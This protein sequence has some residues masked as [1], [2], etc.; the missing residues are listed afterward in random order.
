MA[1]TFD[2][3]IET[4]I[5]TLRDNLELIQDSR[6]YKKYLPYCKELF[7]YA[8]N[9]QSDYLFALYYYYMAEYYATD[10][11]CN[12]TINYALEGIKYQHSAQEYELEARSY[13][14]LGIFTDV[15]EDYSKS[16]D[17]YMSC[18]DLCNTY[19]FDHVHSMAAANLADVFR[20]NSNYERALY[21][22][23]ESERYHLREVKSCNPL[24]YLSYDNRVMTNKGYCLLSIKQLDIA[25][26]YGKKILHNIEILNENKIEYTVFPAHVFLAALFFETGDIEQFEHHMKIANSDLNC[27][28][29]YTSF[30][31]AISVYVQLYMDSKQ[32]ETAVKIID[33]FLDICQKDSAT[34]SVLSCFLEKRIECTQLM[35]D[36][37]GYMYYSKLFFSLY[38]KNKA[39]DSEI[40]IRAENSHKERILIQ[41]Q[42][43]EMYLINKKLLTQSQHD[44][45]TGLPNRSYMNSY[46]ENTLSKALNNRTKLGIEMLD[47][48][49]FKDINDKYGHLEGDRYLTLVADILMKITKN[50]DDI[51]AARYGGD[52]F[53]IIYYNKKTEEINK[54]M[55]D[56]K[57]ASAGISLPCASKVGVDHLSLSQ[58]CCNIIPN[59]FNRIWD[60]MSKADAA[61]YNVKKS[62]RNGF[63]LYD[64]F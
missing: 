62:G 46:A 16:I 29:S 24:D 39:N 27:A 55:L 61:L 49:Y 40:V 22:Y 11:D 19:H 17:Y 30:I 28:D 53:V 50:D 3:N 56:I 21:Y 8:T 44:T 33:Y 64:S 10:N 4:C 14:L 13:N 34:F 12:K 36:T 48:D 32:Y 2:S 15:L 45:L 59:E 60:F 20:S 37:D 9:E 1:P 7:K 5:Q 35:N 51:F 23:E 57:T 47:I 58:G 54:I 63:R 43:N 26:E 38:K 6:H 52:E 42:Q 25:N 18:I 41:E 31:E